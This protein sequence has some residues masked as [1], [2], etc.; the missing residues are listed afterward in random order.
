MKKYILYIVFTFVTVSVK[1]QEYKLFGASINEKV[2]LKWMS[3]Q[4]S[5]ETA[6]DV[7][8]KENENWEKL[9]MNPIVPSPLISANELKSSKNPFPNDEAYAIYVEHY[10]KKEDAANKQ[11]YADYTLAMNSISDNVLAKHRGIYFED[12]NVQKGKTYS[13]KLVDAKSQKELSVINNLTVG[14]LGNAPDNIKFKQNKQNIE[15]VWPINEDYIGYN[16]YRNNDKIN[17][18]LIMPN[19]EK[20]SVSINSYNDLKVPAGNY[21]YIIK[22]VTF[23]NTESNPSQEIKVEVKDATPP[24]VVKGVNAERKNL[25]VTITWK[26][27]TD[28]D[29]VGYN[30]HKSNDMGKNFAKITTQPIKENKYIDVLKKDVSGTLQYKVEAVDASGNGLLSMPVAIFAPDVEAPAKLEDVKGKSEVGKITIS[31]KANSEKDLAGYRIYRGLKNDDENEMLLLNVEPQTAT[32]FVD[33]FNEKASTKFI[34]KVAAVD[35]SYNHSEKAEVWIQLPD[36]IPPTAPFLKEAKIENDEV[37]LNWNPVLTDAIQGYEVYR[38]IDEI[39]EKISTDLVNG[40][41]FVDKIKNRGIIEYYVKAVDSAKLVSSPSNKIAIAT[42]DIKADFS[43]VVNQNIARKKVVLTITGVKPEEIQELIVYRKD[44]DS[45]FRIISSFFTNNEFIDLNSEE[46]QIY[47][48]FVVALLKDDTRLKSEK[49]SIN[50]T[51]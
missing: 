14:N 42:G 13:Y 45:G 50:N 43:L 25:G 10:S 2:Q 48:Y 5:R 47:Q 41:T 11:A 7:Y 35:K 36:V 27:S 19:T 1:A 26:A 24:A 34:Y 15:L 46:N 29:V 51:Y 8:K 31:W 17:G 9:N 30:I 20:G 12:S 44:G 16:L 18:E 6:F 49:I 40:L 33:T 21:V 3:K 22:G 39:D 32:I 28:A 4:I 38:R 37:I 23:L